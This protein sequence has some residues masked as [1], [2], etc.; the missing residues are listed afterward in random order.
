MT[1]VD[2]ASDLPAPVEAEIPGVGRRVLRQ[3][4]ES[5]V[6]EGMLVPHRRGD[7]WELD[8]PTPPGDPAVAYR[9]R[10]SERVAFGRVR[11]DGPVRRCPGRR[12]DGTG[13]HDE[14]VTSPRAFLA[15]VAPLL[16]APPG[17]VAG[18]V[19]ELERTVL[20]DATGLAAWRRRPRPAPDAPYDDVET[21]TVGGHRYHPSYKSRVGFDPDDN[22]RFGP[23]L[24]PSVRPVWLAL[25]RDELEVSAVAGLDPDAFVRSQLG[26]PTCTRFRAALAE[27][28]ATTGG[29]PAAWVPLHPWQWREHLSARLAGAVAGGRAVVLGEA[30][31][32]YRPQQSIRTLANTSHPGKA[33]LKLALGIVNTSTARTLAP[34]TL[35]NAPLVTD[36]LRGI[37]ADD[38]VL[39][40][41]LG[42]GVLGE[43]L[44]VA[45]V[46][47]RPGLPSG[48]DGML[49]CL[50]RDSVPSQLGAG[51][52]AVPFTTLAQPTADGP[53]F[54]AP[55][56]RAWGAERWA[57]R[58][59]EVAVTPLAHLLWAHGVALEAHAQN[60]ILVHRD[61]WPERLLVRDL[62]DGI[63]V[64]RRH[65]AAPDRLPELAA[66]PEAHLRVNRNS[67]V[68]TDDPAAVRDF[69]HDAFFFVNLAEVGFVL[70]DHLGL[71]ERRFWARARDVLDR[72]RRRFPG[73]APRR[74]TFDLLAP[75]VGI[76]QLTTRRL[77]PDDRVRVQQAANPLARVAGTGPPEDRA[78][79]RARAQA[80]ARA[81]P[82]AR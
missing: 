47:P 11:L 2:D 27:R 59:L 35:R 1:G 66:T 10:A 69:V 53:P 16:G 3:L 15:D 60:V 7:D 29:T 61:G 40:D 70:A 22:R 68:E 39:R 64:A 30:D 23:E 46:G 18:L 13:G 34:H 38:P 76:E 77:L 17:R 50:W 45:H 25:P 4:V 5:L 28:G 82:A 33:S 80:E 49:G 42:L 74:A 58:F 36:W 24:G 57:A 8:V 26:E 63:R 20:N 9:W 78:P 62:H 48:P 54:L 37:V 32:D 19:D 6:F 31:D 71:D 44:A 73:L 55:W 75:T 67:F 65:L 41:E 79:D 12:A 21:W 52:R 56:I 81:A 51:E 43:T 14:E 72:H